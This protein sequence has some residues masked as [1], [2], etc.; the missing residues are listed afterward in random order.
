MKWLRSDNYSLPTLFALGLH[1]GIIVAGLVAIDFSD[2]APQ[3][4]KRPPIVN[5]TVIDI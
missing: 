1:V 4:P 3:V 5:A 2:S